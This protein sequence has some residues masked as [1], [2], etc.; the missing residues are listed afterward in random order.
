M[1][2]LF[3]FFLPPAK[4]TLAPYTDSLFNFIMLAS[5][6]IMVG[7]VIAIIY[8]VFKY[9]RK[10]ENDVTPVITHNNTLEITWSVIPLILVLIVF[11]WGFKGFLFYE[12][13]P[14]DA[15]EIQVTGKKWL[16]EF[17]YENGSSSIGELHVPKDRPVRL[18]MNSTDVI[19]SFYVPAFRI[20][21]DVVPGQ[22]TSVWFETNEVGESV[23]FCTEYCGT[24]HSDMMGKIVAH[25]KEGFEDWLASSSAPAEDL[26]PA[27]HG[28]QLVKQNACLTCHSLDG[29]SMTG[30]TFQ[31]IWQREE[32]MN[33]GSTITVDENYIRE[34]ILEPKSKVVQGY[35]PVMPTY[36]GSLSDTE[37]NA[38]IEYLKEQK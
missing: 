15:Y 27:E 35:A 36:Q 32:Q 23:I 16:W 33:D 20:K 4:S 25:D 18:V 31:G 38:I 24:G 21:R 17:K 28:A 3:D 2:N 19:H 11:G 26:P 12:N 9:R 1:S 6:I 13:V 8:F 22:Y 29:S 14:A 7:I 30:P 10:S 37:I 34:S 5:S